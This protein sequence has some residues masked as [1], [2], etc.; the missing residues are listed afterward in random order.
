MELLIT[1]QDIEPL[2]KKINKPF[3]FNNDGI[4]T[5]TYKEEINENFFHSNPKSLFGIKQKVKSKQFN[6]FC[7]VNAILKLSVFAV[8]LIAIL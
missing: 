6:A 4:L 2:P 7:S 5:S 1:S 3:V 8:I